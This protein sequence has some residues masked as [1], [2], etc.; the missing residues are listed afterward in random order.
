MGSESRDKALLTILGSF[1]STNNASK[2]AREAHR[3]GLLTI[4]EALQLDANHVEWLTGSMPLKHSPWA[5]E[6]KTEAKRS[7]QRTEGEPHW[8]AKFIHL[9]WEGQEGE[10]L[11]DDCI[12]TVELAA[13]ELGLTYAGI[14]VRMSLGKGTYTLRGAKYGKHPRKYGYL[15][16]DVTMSRL[17]TQPTDPKVRADLYAAALAHRDAAVARRAK[18]K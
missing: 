15:V 11:D 5:L 8:L 14:S 17:E 13:E 3:A 6:A 2:P 16:G 1:M 9:S 10:D 18:L 12:T 7:A 4:L